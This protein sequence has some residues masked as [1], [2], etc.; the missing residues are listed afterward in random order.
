MILAY[1]TPGQ[2]G[3]QLWAYCNLIAIAKE[4]NAGVII[5]LQQNYFKLLDGD[6]LTAAKKNKI[7]IHDSG[8]YKARIIK[9]CCSVFF[10]NKNRFLAKVFPITIIEDGN[11]VLQKEL[12][13]HKNN[14]YIVNAW[15]QRIHTASFI[16]ENNFIRQLILPEETSKKLAEERIALLRNDYDKIVAV[17]IRRGDYKTFLDGRYYFED[18][19][20]LDKMKQI[21]NILS[22]SKV[23]FA[24][25]SNEKI[26]L[27]NFNGINVSFN[28]DN[29]PIGDMWGISLCDYIIGPLSTFSMW[30]SFWKKVPLLFV[31]KNTEIKSMDIFSPVIAQ[32]LQA[33]GKVTNC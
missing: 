28:N 2:L 30:A 1:D 4:N 14:L 9:K 27:N 13:A 16:N 24:I 33:K 7:H 11:I 20:Y 17:H 22:P 21:N 18:D 8:T 29:S 19:I 32:D 6:A 25:F 10:K 12:G 5:I 3:N 15:E 23:V 31:Q 26:D